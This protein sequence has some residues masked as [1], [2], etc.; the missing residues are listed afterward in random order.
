MG[1]RRCK[2][3]TAPRPGVAALSALLTRREATR[4]VRETMQGEP[5]AF[6]YLLYIA[7]TYRETAET[8]QSGPARKRPAAA[9]AKASGKQRAPTNALYYF[10]EED[11][12]LQQVRIRGPRPSLAPRELKR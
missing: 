10:N 8:D 6:D 9:A 4:S 1:L 7:K 12:F 5:Y 11:E 3:G 2:G